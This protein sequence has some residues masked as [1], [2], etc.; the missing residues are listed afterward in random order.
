MDWMDKKKKK[1]T[2]LTGASD[3]AVGA[4]FEPLGHRM[5]PFLF[6]LCI[7]TGYYRVFY[8]CAIRILNIIFGGFAR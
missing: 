8:H 6:E 7:S 2:E 5:A 3:D 1:K 4:G